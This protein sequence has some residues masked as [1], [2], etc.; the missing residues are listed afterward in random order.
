MALKYTKIL[1]LLSL[2]L[3]F[4]LSGCGKKF[5]SDDYIGKTSAEIIEEHGAFDYVLGD[6]DTEGLYKSTKCGY[7]YKEK[8]VGFLGTSEEEY[9]F[10]HF[11]ENGVAYKCDYGVRPGG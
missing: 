2:L 9:F 11:D 1:F 7:I 5:N 3:I 6:T 10:I 4:V 8:Q